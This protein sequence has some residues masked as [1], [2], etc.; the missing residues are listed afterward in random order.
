LEAEGAEAPTKPILMAMP[1]TSWQGWPGDGPP[2]HD[3]PY[4]SSV[5]QLSVT[6]MSLLI[7]DIL[8]MS[9]CPSFSQIEGGGRGSM[10]LLILMS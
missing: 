10:S 4:F 5:N 8:A 7:L 2:F 6:L 3:I 9:R 1:A